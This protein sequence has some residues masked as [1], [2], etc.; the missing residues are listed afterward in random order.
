[1]LAQQRVES[2]SNE[3]TAI[4][5]LLNLLVLFGAII[6][7]DAMG[8]Q[9]NIAAQIIQQEG[10]YILSLKG[11]QCNLHKGVKEFFKKAEVTGW[12][13]IEYTYS[14]TI[15]AGHHRTERRQVW[16]MSIN[17][18]PDLPNAH[19]W[20]GKRQCGDGEAGTTALE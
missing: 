19:K 4:P 8:T 17:Q 3:I 9:T 16:A 12:E 1:M 6:T 5:E 13:G 10:D 11:N 7:L 14:E 15:E 18:L 20:K 2:K